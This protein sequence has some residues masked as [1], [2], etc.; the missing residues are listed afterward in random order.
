MKLTTLVWI[1]IAV[2]ALA[3]IGFSS[4]TSSRPWKPTP[5]QIAA[6]YGSITHNKQ[7]GNLVTI[8]WHASP[9]APP[10]SQLVSILEKYVLISVI[11]S[12]MNLRE[13]A[14]GLHFDD[15]DKLEVRDD[16]GNLLT[17]IDQ[18]KLPPTSIGILATFEAGYRQEL[19][20]RGK[21]T[22]FFLFAAGAVHACEKGGISV[23]YD[24]E[25]YTWETPF[26][27][28]SANAFGQQR[29]ADGLHVSEPEPA[30]PV[31]GYLDPGGPELGNNFL[32]AF[33]K[34]M[35][36]TGLVVGQNVTIDYRYAHYEYDRLLNAAADLVRRRVTVIFANGQPAII[37]AKA[38]TATIPIVFMTGADPVEFGFERSFN[39]PA[40]NLTGVAY[41][42]AEVT[43]KRFNLLHELV[44]TAKTIAFVAGGYGSFNQAETRDLENASRA[45]GVNLLVLHASTASEIEKVFTIPIEYG[46]L[47]IRSSFEVKSYARQII[48]LSAGHAIPTMFASSGYTSA[49]GLSSYGSRSGDAEYQVGLYVGQILKGRKPTELPIVQPTKFEFVINLQ[50]AKK[51]G[52]TVPPRVLAV[53]ERLIE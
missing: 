30:I 33:R 10:G 49:G 51:I 26:P 3:C 46:A 24:G 7:S 53:A 43:A 4:S 52:L 16:S 6:D 2:V 20:P 31:I 29:R 37:A 44:P 12:Q 40:G 25:T 47:L 27:G 36:E 48:S 9:A 21:G 19:G 5:P 14:T 41:Q 45:V 18:D 23:P 13:S 8:V 22:R 17:P 28:C 42:S 35:S 32:A 38:A 39:R 34:G 15:I 50:T 1:G 11:R